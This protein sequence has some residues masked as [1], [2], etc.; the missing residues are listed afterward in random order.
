[1]ALPIIDVPTFDLKIPGTK[2]TVSFRPFLVKE[3][4][5]LTLASE[6]EDMA[7]MISACMQIVQNCSFGKV[8]PKKLAMYQLQWV[9]LELKKKSIG[10]VQNFSLKCGGCETVIPYEMNLDEFKVIGDSSSENKR[11]K[12][13]NEVSFVL[14]YPSCE[15]QG[16]LKD[17]TDVEVL[18]ACLISIENGDEVIN[19]KDESVEDLTQFIESLPLSVIEDAE[20]FFKD[21]PFIGHE[22]EYTCP[23]CSRENFILINGYEHFFG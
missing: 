9:F 8:D 17:M 23:K 3:D 5:L 19:T 10:V 16:L 7:E 21:M 14:K 22:V 12:V 11:I 1:M 2:E 15:L 20:V 18:Q 13:N 6:G 4:K